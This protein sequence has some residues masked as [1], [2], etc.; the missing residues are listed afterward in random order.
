[1][2]AIERAQELAANRRGWI[3]AVTMPPISNPQEHHRA[4]IKPMSPVRR[5]DVSSRAGHRRAAHR[6][7]RALKSEWPGLKPL[8]SPTLS[9]V[10]RRHPARPYPSIGR[11][12]PPE[13]STTQ[14][15][16]GATRSMRRSKG[17]ARVRP[18]KKPAGRHLQRRGRSR[19]SP[20]AAE[21]ETARGYSDSTTTPGSAISRSRTFCRRSEGA[22][23]L[24]QAQHERMLL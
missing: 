23:V 24:Q 5:H 4:E 12:L 1:M 13:N 3:R 20:K 21:L 7:S 2:R 8:R 11:R 15:I 16:D 6:M 18:A 10:T 17:N 9:P 19:R 22:R 14:A